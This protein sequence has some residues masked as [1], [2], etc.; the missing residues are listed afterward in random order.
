MSLGAEY[1]Q[2]SLGAVH[3]DKRVLDCGQR[4]SLT[5]RVVRRS[6]QSQ[7]EPQSNGE[8]K[9]AQGPSLKKCQLR[10]NRARCGGLSGLDRGQH[11]LEATQ[12]GLRRNLLGPWK[13][14]SRS[15]CYISPLG[16]RPT[17]QLDCFISPDDGMNQ[18]CRGTDMLWPEQYWVQAAGRESP[19][20]Q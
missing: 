19:G 15:G 2:P 5:G 10:K 18:G 7:A 17:D 8:W 11:C 16:N 12:H 13:S 20:G 6:A 1:L 4:E 3:V 14:L 9:Q